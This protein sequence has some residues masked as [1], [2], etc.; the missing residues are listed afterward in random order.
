MEEIERRT[1]RGFQEIVKP[2][3]SNY[4]E[5]QLGRAGETVSMHQDRIIEENQRIQDE[6]QSDAKEK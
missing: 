2:S 3:V 6:I 5:V 4:S 1:G